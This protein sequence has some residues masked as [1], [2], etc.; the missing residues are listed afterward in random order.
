M[1]DVS[2]SGWDVVSVTDPD[3]INEIINA[4]KDVNV[5]G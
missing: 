1:T 4:D 3:T 2:T 5:N